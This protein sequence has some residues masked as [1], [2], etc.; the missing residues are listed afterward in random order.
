MMNSMEHCTRPAE[1]VDFLVNCEPSR[2]N[3]KAQIR[4]GSTPESE[5]IFNS[6][7]RDIDG[8]QLIG[9][10]TTFFD[11]TTRLIRFETLKQTCLG[12]LIT[13]DDHS[14][15]VNIVCRGED[16]VLGQTSPKGILHITPQCRQIAVDDILTVQS[17]SIENLLLVRFEDEYYIRFYDQQKC[18]L[19]LLP[20]TID[21]SK[22]FACFGCKP[23]TIKE[24][25][26][27][28]CV[29]FE[30][31]LKIAT[32]NYFDNANSRD[33][34]DYDEELYPERYRKQLSDLNKD[35]YTRD[36]LTSSLHVG[37]V[38]AIVRDNDLGVEYLKVNL[39]YRYVY[40][41]CFLKIHS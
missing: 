29:I 21:S 40:C 23:K 5:H 3:K 17:I 4:Y 14:C 7:F 34:E 9:E 25:K 10:A 19:Q 32:F 12:L 38:Q 37:Y 16:T 36:D 22:Q 26:R 31:N 6:I 18:S 2:A 15:H 33:D 27:G 11:R 13:S 20:F 41:L 39:F 28:D 8:E 24:I 35:C 1:D 30:S